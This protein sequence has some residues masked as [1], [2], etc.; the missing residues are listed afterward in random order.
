[1]DTRTSL[2]ALLLAMTATASHAEGD[3]PCEATSHVDEM[4]CL[5]QELTRLD[6]VLDA[7]YPAAL[8][9]RPESDDFDRRKNREQ[10]RQS[11]LA[12]RHYMEENCD[13]L[14]GLEGGGNLWVSDF[15]ARCRKTETEQRIEFLGRVANGSFGG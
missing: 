6:Q 11:Q 14:G 1:M 10:L 7:A 13:L 2:G 3:V 4:R 15:A 8:A 9:A 5:G 12:W